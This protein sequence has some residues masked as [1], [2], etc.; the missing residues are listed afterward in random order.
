MECGSQQQTANEQACDW[1]QYAS[2]TECINFNNDIFGHDI[3][4]NDNDINDDPTFTLDDINISELSDSDID[5]TDKYF[6]DTTNQWK[7]CGQ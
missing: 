1:E 7:Q 4:D 2:L 3:S 6:I 5:M